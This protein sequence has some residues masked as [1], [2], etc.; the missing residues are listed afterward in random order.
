MGARVRVPIELRLD[1]VTP[2][3]HATPERVGEALR[4][5][6][7][8]ALDAAPWGRLGA[9]GPR[10]VALTDVTVTAAPGSEGA[11]TPAVVA[12]ACAGAG[13]G[14]RSA[15]QRQLRGAPGR[16]VRPEGAPDEAFDPSRRRG[17]GRGATYRVPFF[18]GG[19]IEVPL[20]EVES[21][22]A[23]VERPARPPLPPAGATVGLHDALTIA[24]SWHVHRNGPR[25]E[26]GTL[27]RPGYYG[28]VRIDG[29]V[30]STLVW[31][32]DVRGAIP[33]MGPPRSQ[34]VSYLTYPMLIIEPPTAGSDQLRRSPLAPSFD[35]WELRASGVA[36]T[37][38]TVEVELDRSARASGS[39]DGAPPTDPDRRR[40]H[41][42]ALL[43]YDDGE[44]I[45]D[46]MMWSLRGPTEGFAVLPQLIAGV[47]VNGPIRFVTGDAT[48]GSDIGSSSRLRGSG[49]GTGGGVGVGSGAGRGRATDRSGSRRAARGSS[50]AG[51]R[52]G[53]VARRRPRVA[54]GPLGTES[55]GTRL[56]PTAGIDGEAM[57]CAPYL[58]E[59]TAADLVD[60][61]GLSTA[62]QRLAALL[63]IDGCGYL[64]RFGLKAAS[65]VATRARGVGLASV[66]ATA[67][68]LVTYRA[69][70]SGNNGFLDVRPG[71][72][73]DFEYLRELA[74]IAA[75]VSDFCSAVISCYLDRRN[76]HLVRVDED[77]EPSAAGWALRY[78][79]ESARYSTAGYMHLYAETCRV[80]LLQQLRASRPGILARAGRHFPET[81]QAFSSALDILG[82][83]VVQ[84]SVLARAIR[85]SATVS[86]TGTVREVLAISQTVGHGMDQM[87]LPAPI[88]GV[89][90]RILAVIGD[91]RVERR[92]SARIA[93]FSGREWTREDLQL[94]VNT[95]RGL[96]NQVDP[97]FLQVGDLDALFAGS[98][99]DEAHVERHLRGLLGQMLE[100]NTGMLTKS[101]D[102]DDGAF[103]ALQT[104][105]YVEREGGRDSSG[106]RFELHGIHALADDQLAPHVRGDLFYARGRTA[107]IA[108]RADFDA[109]LALFSTVGIIALG[110][111]CAPLLGALA[112]AAAVGAAGLVLTLH[113]VRE[114][115]QQEERYRS[116]LDPEL[117]LR[118][119]EV[120]LAQMMAA[121][122]IAFSVFDV[123]PVGRLA[124]EIVG[125]AT[126]ALRVGE[127]AGARMAI[128]S[129]TRRTRKTI[130]AS[131]TTDVLEKAVQQA[132]AETVVVTAMNL[133]L[134]SVIAPVLV[135]WVREQAA[136]HGTLAEVDAALGPLAA[137]QPALGAPAPAPAPVLVH[138]PPA[139]TDGAP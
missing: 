127:R 40:A 58:A 24:W 116:I 96:L 30:E 8:R 135:P 63:E 9:R 131:M 134:P 111:F 129:V 44:L 94:G 42:E 72:S 81:L 25:W 57:E 61:H 98:L 115:D 73:P 114:A 102:P 38:E 75:D 5:A 122:S 71:A 104:S 128:T 124:R 37:V 79:A 123:V 56:W 13:D 80:L 11:L 86:A 31:L 120:E 137:G 4:L 41:A 119:Q 29:H 82:E 47:T 20:D 27:G 77:R 91:A 101:A 36:A 110:L 28:R 7:A 62:M 74:R 2:G 52:P 70:G 68:T 17:R 54:G 78:S 55:A 112:A 34:D 23:Q 43:V 14:A 89:P 99:R 49:G 90:Q 60:D 69:D 53:D 85:H 21:A 3:H 103:F 50:A 12:A 113:D 19:E 100:A 22:A 46:P 97:L 65:T 1:A 64:G 109:F 108:R 126:H 32:S 35:G 26:P 130:L 107:A 6:S 139:P 136:Q 16:T 39:A 118:W 138:A 33:A 88:L 133:L 10:D 125:A 51:D 121:L 105:Q 95:R 66:R 59:P 15:L 76:A 117:F 132:I 84:L 87:E 83:S 93:V 45:V 92:G 18:D 67:T 106:T 48:S